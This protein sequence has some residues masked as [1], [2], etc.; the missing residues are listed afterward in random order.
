MDDMPFPQY[1]KG[2]PKAGLDEVT[3]FV[4]A[5]A[6]SAFPYFFLQMALGSWAYAPVL[7]GAVAWATFRYVAVPAVRYVFQQ[8]PPMYLEHYVATV[9]YRGGLAARPDPEPIPFKVD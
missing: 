1:R 3:H 5:I 4:L 7:S 8:L 6:L 9:F 2:I